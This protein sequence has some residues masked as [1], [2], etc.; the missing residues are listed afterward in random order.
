MV[1]DSD[2]IRYITAAFSGRR[3]ARSEVYQWL[4]EHHDTLVRA[5][6]AGHGRTDWIGVT[7]GLR[8]AGVKGEND[9]PLKPESIRRCWN[10]VA[11]DVKSGLIKVPDTA[12]PGRAAA[13]A[14]SG[15]EFSSP[16]KTPGNTASSEPDFLIPDITGKKI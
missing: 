10:R 16:V 9:K 13:S 6:D 1:R 15:T 5:K 11:T 14:A 3:R 8:Q 2:G 7:I 4:L 12:I